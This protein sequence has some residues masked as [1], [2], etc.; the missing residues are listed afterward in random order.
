MIF[1]LL[2][3][4]SIQ[5]LSILAE[6]SDTQDDWLHVEKEKIVDK[7]GKEVW[8]TGVNW[9]GF[10][11]GSGV[12]D[13]VWAINLK[14]A[15]GEIADHGFNLLRVPVSVEIILQW[16]NGGK[17]KKIPQVNGYVNEE[18]LEEDVLR[19]RGE[20]QQTQKQRSKR[21]TERETGDAESIDKRCVGQLGR[22]RRPSQGT[23]DVYR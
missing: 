21:R 3:I 9:F 6:D 4:L 13:G 10:N 17:D 18:L 22:G 2:F 12:F 8:L 20:I 14:K 16:K 1:Y 19:N 15:L 5:I 23:A 11:T 7:N